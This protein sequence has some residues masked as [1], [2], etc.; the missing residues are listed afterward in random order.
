MFRTTGLVFG[1][2][3]MFLS[4]SSF[5]AGSFGDP[6]RCAMRAIAEWIFDSELTLKHLSVTQEWGSTL[7]FHSNQYSKEEL[8]ANGSIENVRYTFVGE[9]I[10]S[11]M[12]QHPFKGSASVDF[13][14]NYDQSTGK[15]IKTECRVH[16]DTKYVGY[17]ND[18]RIDTDIINVKLKNSGEYLIEDGVKHWDKLYNKDEVKHSSNS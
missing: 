11:D 10:S 8:L 6:T 13:T 5:A 17:Y 7:S 16:V 9:A 3:V 18:Q 4:Q 14:N 12:N 1:L 15:Y 2:A